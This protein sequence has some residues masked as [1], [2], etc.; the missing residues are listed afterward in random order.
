MI[1]SRD[2]VP[3]EYHASRNSLLWYA[4][5]VVTILYLSCLTTIIKFLKLSDVTLPISVIYYLGKMIGYWPQRKYFPR[6]YRGAALQQ[7]EL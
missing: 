1:V 4:C 6:P 2:F 5:S 3:M 7:T